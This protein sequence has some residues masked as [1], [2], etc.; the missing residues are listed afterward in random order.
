MTMTLSKTTVCNL[1]LFTM[2]N[3][4]NN[5]NAICNAEFHI[6]VLCKVWHRSMFYAKSNDNKY[7]K[8]RFEIIKLMSELY[9]GVRSFVA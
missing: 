2:K 6:N 4:F 1:P 9:L 3:P 5:E 8:C 7:S